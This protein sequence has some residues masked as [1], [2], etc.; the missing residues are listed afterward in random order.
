MSNGQGGPPKKEHQRESKTFGKLSEPFW[1]LLAVLLLPSSFFVYESYMQ[2]GTI[3]DD[4]GQQVESETR[5]FLQNSN[6]AVSVTFF[7]MRTRVTLEQDVMKLR[8]KRTTA[9]LATRTWMRFMSLMFGAILIVIGCAFVLGRI[10]GPAFKGEG[11]L[12]TL[13]A[14]VVSSSPGLILVFFGAALVSV[15]NL[16]TQRIITDDT[17]TY[18]DTRDPNPVGA[19]LDLEELKGKYNLNEENK[20]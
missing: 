18:L 9:Y 3:L 6:S 11:K 1:I 15:P 10:R 14:S 17:A 2:L 5:E 12:G 16:S 8:H 20:E 13:R 7:R 4:I 19:G